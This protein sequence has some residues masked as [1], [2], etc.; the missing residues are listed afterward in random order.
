MPQV[1]AALRGMPVSYLGALGGIALAE[2]YGAFDLFV[3]PGTE[4]TFGQTLQEA[5][6]SGLPVIAP[7]AGGPIDLVES[8][9]D[10]Y[11]YEPD[12]D[13][14]L[15]ELV[16]R[17]ASD[18]RMRH[19]MGEAGRRAVLGRSWASVC[20]ELL[21]HYGSVISAARGRRTSLLESA[22]SI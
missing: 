5:H 19:R 15:R 17:L 16:R 22:Q 20:E 14:G 2:A 11:L 18:S 21:G 8:G 7:R 1:R 9:V 6:A 3:H 13:L 10:G 4:E 12:D